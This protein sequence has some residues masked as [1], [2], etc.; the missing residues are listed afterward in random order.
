MQNS[1]YFLSEN[2]NQYSQASQASHSYPVQLAIQS[3]STAYCCV[4]MQSLQ[5][6]LSENRNQYSQANQANHC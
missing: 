3:M 1:W 2:R 5:Y 4:E 6:F